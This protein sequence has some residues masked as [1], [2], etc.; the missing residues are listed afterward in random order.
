M[1]V[2]DVLNLISARYEHGHDVLVDGCALCEEEYAKVCGA[3]CH[4]ARNYMKG[5]SHDGG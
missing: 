1:N 4:M 5:V 3:L 2:T